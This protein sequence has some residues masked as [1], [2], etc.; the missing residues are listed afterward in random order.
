LAIYDALT[1]YKGTYTITWKARTKS[2]H[3]ILLLLHILII[4]VIGSAWIIGLIFRHITNPL[5][6]ISGA[7]IALSSLGI[8]LTCC[9]EFPDPYDPELEEKEIGEWLTREGF[10]HTK[11]SRY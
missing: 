11:N 5:L 7:I 6:Y 8:I 4:S 3:S 10:S 9:L 2:R 1:H